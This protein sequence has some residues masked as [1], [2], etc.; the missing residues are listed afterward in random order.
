MSRHLTKK[1]REPGD[2]KS[3]PTTN[4]VTG[5]ETWTARQPATVYFFMLVY[6]SC[7]DNNTKG[8]AEVMCECHQSK[9]S[10][11]D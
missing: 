10:G 6:D 5:S 1:P 2:S 8:T 9:Q 7:C 3:R 11:N 4:E